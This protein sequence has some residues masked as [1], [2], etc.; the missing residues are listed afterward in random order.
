MTD[1]YQLDDPPD[2]LPMSM[3]P[4]EFVEAW[5]QVEEDVHQ[6]ALDHGWWDKPRSEGD[7]IA[8]MH[9]E[10]SEALEAVRHGNPP[11][12]KA[13]GFSE[14]EEELADVVIRMMDW[15][16]HAGLNVAGAVVAKIE[17]NRSRPYRH[18]GKAL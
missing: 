5:G 17:H 11:S 18:G 9:S 14:L 7:I 8:L 13:A 15:A 12:T 16:R 1:K 6:I 4:Q 10:L 2:E 3:D